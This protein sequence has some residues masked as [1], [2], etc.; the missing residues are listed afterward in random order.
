MTRRPHLW[1]RG[2]GAISYNLSYLVFLQGKVNSA[3]YITQVVNPILRSFLQQD[4]DV[5]FLQDNTC[6]HAA[7][8]TQHAICGIR[9]LPWQARTPDLSPIEDV[10]EGSAQ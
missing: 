5:L 6:L 4:G 9:Q 3:H 7:A 10:K 2:V 8:V 1:V